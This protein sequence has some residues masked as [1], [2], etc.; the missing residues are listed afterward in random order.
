ME[1][2]PIE[3]K[4]PPEDVGGKG[5]KGAPSHRGI[6]HGAIVAYPR[7]RPQQGE[8]KIEGP[9]KM[10][11]KIACVKSGSFNIFKN[12]DIVTLGSDMLRQKAE[13]IKPIHD[14]YIKIAAEMIDALHAGQGV[15]LAGPQVGLLKRIFVTHFEGDTPRVFINPTII[16][17]SAELVKYEEGCLS[18]PGIY[19]E[20]IRPQAV[21]IQAWNERGRPFTLEAD[22]FLARIIQHEYDHLE[23]VLFLDRLSEPKRNRMINKY[24]RLK[25]R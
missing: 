23:G 9:G 17:T 19:A 10:P 12:M 24:E 1:E 14:D 2:P 6:F 4:D 16:E 21:K 22:G 7:K 13:P 18:I 20:V 25:K 15:G 8:E 5:V 3:G 11:D